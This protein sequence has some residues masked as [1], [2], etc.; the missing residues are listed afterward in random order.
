MVRAEAEMEV[1]GGPEREVHRVL[2]LFELP[3]PFGGRM[4]APAGWKRCC[5]A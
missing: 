4:A 3:Q 5:E 2:E 1:E